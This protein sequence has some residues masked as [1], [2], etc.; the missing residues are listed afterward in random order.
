MN[1]QEFDNLTKLSRLQL[2]DR[3][4]EAFQKDFENI[5]N[6]VAQLAEVNTDDV[7]PLVQASGLKNVFRQDSPVPSIGVDVALSNAPQREGSSFKVPNVI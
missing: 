4:K 5:I 3:D 7:E 6:Y 1:K 2:D